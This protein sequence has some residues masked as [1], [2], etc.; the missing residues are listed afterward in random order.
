MMTVVTF[1]YVINKVKTPITIC[2]LP[3][4]DAV[5]TVIKR[6]DLTGS[7]TKCS[8]NYQTATQDL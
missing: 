4:I 8:K 7:N 1:Q 2:K 5:K 3:D 6:L